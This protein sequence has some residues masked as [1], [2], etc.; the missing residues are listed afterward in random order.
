MSILHWVIVLGLLATWVVPPL[1][2]LTKAGYS[3]WW[4]LLFLVPIANIIALWI[5]AFAD[6]PNLASQSPRP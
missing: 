4:V 1:K 6:W 3:G 2:I 5:F